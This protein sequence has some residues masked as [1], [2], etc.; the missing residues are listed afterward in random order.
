[1]RVVDLGCGT[2]KLTRILHERLQ[3]LDTLGIDRSARMLES[4]LAAA[5]VTGLRFEVQTIDAFLGGGG[6][7]DLLFSN[8]V[9]HWVDGH[10]TL[11]E[12]LAS[13]LASGGQLAF[14]VPANHADPSHLVADELTQ[15]EP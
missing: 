12:R 11:L 9:F 4:A 1:M 15:V 5:P 6:G 10:E 3:A 7:Y 2:G 14:Q 8:A 13:R